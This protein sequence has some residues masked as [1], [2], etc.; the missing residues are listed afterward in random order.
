[1]LG[2]D[3]LFDGEPVTNQFASVSLQHATVLSAGVSLNEF[4]FPPHSG[5]NVVFD[6]GGPIVIDFGFAARDVSAYFTYAADLT[7]TA[8]DQ[9]LNPLEIASSAFSSNLAMS[10]DTG[11]TP[12]ELIS[13]ASPEVWRL[14]IQ[15]D[16]LGGSFTM[17]DLAFNA[18]ASAPVPPTMALVLPG[19][20]L[21]SRLQ[22]RRGEHL[23]IR[24]GAR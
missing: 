10:G 2:F 4:E 17:D 24:G 9:S 8:F 13:V 14:V 5:N 21:I 16:P 19:I 7:V 6:D 22:R 20:A 3:A 11:S 18:A 12:N 1:M 23:A 15:G